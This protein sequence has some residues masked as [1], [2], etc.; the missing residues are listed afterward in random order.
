MLKTQSTV[1]DG[2]KTMSNLFFK[3]SLTCV[4]NF[5]RDAA[6]TSLQDLAD[7]TAGLCFWTSWFNKSMTGS[8][9]FIPAH[10]K[11]GRFGIVGGVRRHQRLTGW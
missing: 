6:F 4:E 2:Y 9:F 10:Q 1:L 8:C 3:K 5:I 11:H 7:R